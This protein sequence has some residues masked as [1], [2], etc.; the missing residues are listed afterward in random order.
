[1]TLKIPTEC[2]FLSLTRQIIFF[3]P[4]LLIL[5]VFL[6]VDGCIYTGPIA[7]FVAAMVT[8]VMAVL[9]FRKMPK[10]A[11]IREYGNR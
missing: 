8:I 11:V 10:T 3:V 9:E 6:G 4:L 1:M 7:D 5:P 2:V